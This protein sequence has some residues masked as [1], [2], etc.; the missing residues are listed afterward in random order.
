MVMTAR[1]VGVSAKF[2]GSGGAIVGTYQD[3]SQFAEFVHALARIGCKTFRPTIAVDDASAEIRTAANW[4][5][6]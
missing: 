1:S 3:D 6:S 2:A 4:R 5:N